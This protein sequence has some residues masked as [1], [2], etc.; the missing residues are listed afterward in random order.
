MI[1]F[2][3]NHVKQFIFLYVISLDKQNDRCVEIFALSKLRRKTM[4][5]Y[6]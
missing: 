3:M 2:L 6:Q 5:E 4:K 1:D